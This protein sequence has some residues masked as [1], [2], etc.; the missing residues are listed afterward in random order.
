MTW[1]T[2]VF[3]KFAKSETGSYAIEGVLILPMVIWAVMASVVFVDA[4]RMQT[5]NLRATYVISDAVSRMWDPVTNDYFE[6]LWN[7]HGLQVNYDHQTEMRM[8]VIQWSESQQEYVMRWSQTTDATRYPYLD[9][10]AV[11]AR[12][13]TIPNLAD[14]DS[15]VLVETWMDY[16]PVFSVGL[17][18]M[19]FSNYIFV[20]PRYAP[21]IDYNFDG[22]GASS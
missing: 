18:D 2:K 22:T 1:I 4:F 21:Q 10:A 15:L 8:S 17:P 9:Q 13:D 11:D 3:R 12:Q 7:L 20:S 19:V 6:G 16:E 5:L 14:G